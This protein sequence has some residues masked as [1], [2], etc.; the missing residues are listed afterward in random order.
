[1]ANAPNVGNVNLKNANLNNSNSGE[2]NKLK[3]ISF[4]DGKLDIKFDKALTKEGFTQKIAEKFLN[5][6]TAMNSR[7]SKKEKE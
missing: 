1:M 7:S 5:K 2:Y 3:S 6:I 4:K